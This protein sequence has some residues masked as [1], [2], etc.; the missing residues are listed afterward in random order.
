MPAP[1]PVSDRNR[2]SSVLKW[3]GWWS[4][5]AS[6]LGRSIKKTIWRDLVSKS[7]SRAPRKAQPRSATNVLHDASLAPVVRDQIRSGYY[8]SEVVGILEQ[9]EFGMHRPGSIHGREAEPDARWR[10]G[11][12]FSLLWQGPSSAS[13]SC[14]VSRIPKGGDLESVVIDTHL[15]FV[16][17]ICHE[18]Q[19][20]PPE[21][22]L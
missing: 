1:T 21:V 16:C 18:Q 22:D 2:P 7:C 11:L 8:H 9:L 10:V 20:G 17:R 6:S 12:H 4:T 5:E 15:G 3:V 19:L 14:P 13:R